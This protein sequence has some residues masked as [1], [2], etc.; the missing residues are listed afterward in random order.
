MNDLLFIS[1][2]GESL[3]NDGISVVLYR[4]FTSFVEIKGENL[5]A[6]DYVSGMISFFVIALGGIVVGLL[7]AMLTAFV[8]KSIA[9]IYLK[10]KYFRYTE[11]V[12]VLNPIF[13]FLIPFVSYLGA[14]MVSLSA[15]MAYVWISLAETHVLL[16]DRVLWDSHEALHS[17]EH[18]Q[19]CIQV[20]SLL[21]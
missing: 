12:P 2:F 7:F 20:D 5:I 19:R 1:V 9:L 6:I 21:C 16:Q 17:G 8:T 3:L 15:I 18:H 14:E 13:V 10:E 4:M 11:K